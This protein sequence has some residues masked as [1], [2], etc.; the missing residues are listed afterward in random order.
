MNQLEGGYLATGQYENQDGLIWRYAVK[1]NGN[2]TVW[3]RQIGNGDYVG[4]TN[5]LAFDA[6]QT[7]DGNYLV[8][9]RARWEGTGSRTWGTLTKLGSDG[10][11]LW[12]QSYEEIK[13]KSVRSISD[14]P[15]S[16]YLVGGS[17][18]NYGSSGVF[19]KINR[20]GAVE[21]NRSSQFL[22]EH[23]ERVNDNKYL[24]VGR[25]SSQG[26]ASLIDS[27]GNLLWNHS[28]ANSMFM[29][30]IE[31]QNRQLMVVGQS[32]GSNRNAIVRILDSDGRTVWN[33][34][35]D[36]EGDNRIFAVERTQNNTYLLAGSTSTSKG[37]TSYVRG[38]KINYTEGTD[39][40][41]PIGGF[42]N[43]PTDPDDDGKFEDIN[44]DESFTITDVQ[45]FFV[46]QN[47]PVVENHP[48]AFDFNEDSDVTITDVQ[49]LFFEL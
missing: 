6:Q 36:S 26:R 27:R 49:R 17:D 46:H 33:R 11:T 2:E 29:D 39:I 48:D 35:Y 34:T 16:G 31:L 5:D 43:P 4:S 14:T 25:N 23:I 18:R 15:E 19:A 24:L 41:D 38:V 8:A 9:G 47:D 40:T 10:G 1:I 12:N 28:N 3:E 21:W 45:G 20:T 32:A 44:G 30:A 7:S 37:E 42:S 13:M 22:I